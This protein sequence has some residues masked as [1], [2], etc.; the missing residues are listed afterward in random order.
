ML[1]LLGAAP[2]AGSALLQA[3]GGT[4]PEPAGDEVAETASA[5]SVDLQSWRELRPGGAY[6]RLVAKLAAAD[7]FSGTVLLAYRGRPV[8]ELAYGMAD[9]ARSIPNQM[10]TLFDV[11][12]I[13][14]T[15][16][17]V[18]IMQLAQQNEIAFD[19]TIGKFLDGFPAEVAG[20]VT[21]HQLLTHTSGIG[22]Y[23]QF[24]EY[25]EASKTWSSVEEVFEGTVNFIR[26]MPR[27]PEFTPG[28]RWRYS[29][30]GYQVLGAIVAAVSK[31]KN[32]YDYVRKHVF[33]PARMRRTDFYT[34]PQ[35]LAADDVAHPY[36]TDPV[37]GE[38]VDSTLTEMFPFVGTPAGG[39][40]S[41]VR[42]LLNFVR[43]LHEDGTLLEPAF[44]E[45]ATSGKMVV[46]AAFG[47]DLPRQNMFWAYGFEA[48]TFNHRRIRGHSGGSTL[49]ASNMLS[50]YPDL[51]WVSV[52]LS[53][54]PD[55]NAEM[56]NLER[57][58][59]TR[60]R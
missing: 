22:E 50:F 42:E 30:A 18:A 48:T 24:R 49:G 36:A 55:R 43:A 3:C 2:V 4:E 47:P 16:T 21:V 26:G 1:G 28:T 31:E 45:L 54:Y 12:S 6:G 59:I 38:R 13:G 19:D 5:S 51:N 57:D 33:L 17:A 46:P 35:I 25:W 14:K 41:T 10:D 9:K 44:A 32:Y 37:T 40:H 15:F 27:Q 20:T 34:K 23:A 7:R 60:R 29:N 58:L 39:A 53:N 11:A 8:L 56:V 52:S